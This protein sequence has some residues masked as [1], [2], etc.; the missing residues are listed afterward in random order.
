MHILAK[1]NYK[2]ENDGWN[3]KSNSELIITKCVLDNLH[4]LF[5]LKENT[6]YLDKMLQMKNG[7]KSR[8]SNNSNSLKH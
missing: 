6:A 7:T 3:N 4:T 2:A 8:N 1:W 5:E